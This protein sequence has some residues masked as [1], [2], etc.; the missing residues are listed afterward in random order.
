MNN[1]RCKGG[2]WFQNNLAPV[3]IRDRLSPC[4]DN[5]DFIRP[6]FASCNGPGHWR[7]KDIRH[8]KRSCG[9][10]CPPGESLWKRG[11]Q[12][13]R[14]GPYE[15]GSPIKGLVP[16]KGRRAGKRKNISPCKTWILFRLRPSSAPTWCRFSSCPEP[17]TSSLQVHGQIVLIRTS[18]S[19]SRRFYE[20]EAHRDH[21]GG[22]VGPTLRSAKKPWPIMSI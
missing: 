1:Q 5:Q 15:N 4:P 12:H 19:P 14:L 21:W 10:P 13:L 7:I 3:D 8:Q 6:G 18:H 2:R 17:V 11:H 16:P 9:F 20:P 22:S